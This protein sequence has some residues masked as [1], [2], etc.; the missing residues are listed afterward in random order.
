MLRTALQI[1]LAPYPA[2]GVGWPLADFPGGWAMAGGALVEYGI[3]DTARP[4]FQV[5]A[6]VWRYR[7][8]QILALFLVARGQLVL[9]ASFPPRWWP[10]R[11]WR[12]C[13]C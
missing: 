11:W 3:R 6:A 12:A 1:V 5:R 4:R 13:S 2:E 9:A 7:A 8:A 10:P